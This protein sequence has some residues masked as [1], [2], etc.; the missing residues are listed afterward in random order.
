[1]DGVTAVRYVEAWLQRQLT[2]KAAQGYAI[3]GYYNCWRYVPQ[4]HFLGWTDRYWSVSCE[5]ISQDPHQG[6]VGSIVG[7]WEFKVDESGRVYT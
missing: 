3:G 2:E 7:T 5:F 1:M 6:A 4:P